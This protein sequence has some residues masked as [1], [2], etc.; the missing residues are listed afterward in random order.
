MRKLR[1][2]PDTFVTDGAGFKPDVFTRLGIYSGNE[3]RLPPTIFTAKEI[4]VEGG[5]GLVEEKKK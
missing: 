1:E 2:K 4:L 3:W 5:G